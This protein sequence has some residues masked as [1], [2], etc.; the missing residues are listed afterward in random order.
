MGLFPGVALANEIAGIPRIVDGDTVQIGTAKIR[1][2]GIDSLETDQL[3]LDREGKRWTCGVEARDRLIQKAGGKTWTCRTNSVDRYG[4][5][6]ATC[7]AEG[8]DI[9]RWLVR[10]GWALSFIRYSHVYDSD[11]RLAAEQQKLARFLP[12]PSSA[13]C[14][15]VRPGC[16]RDHLRA[17]AIATPGAPSRVKKL[18]RGRILCF[19]VRIPCSLKKFPVRSSKIPC[20]VA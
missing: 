20:S 2:E 3:C 13:L 10:E 4:R 8:T 6:L 19:G 17:K 1:L 16:A 18:V 5:A 15:R 12:S 7:E 14:R 9:N 11:G